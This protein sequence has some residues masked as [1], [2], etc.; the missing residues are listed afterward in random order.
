MNHS[1]KRIVGFALI[2]ALAI[3]V[4]AY[5]VHHWDLMEPAE[6]SQKLQGFGAWGPV[7]IIVMMV[8]HSFVPIP[9]EVLALTAGAVFGTLMGAVLIWIGAMLGA[10]LSYWIAYK[11]GAAGLR[12]WAPAKHVKT[13]DKWTEAPSPFALL[14]ARFMPI[15]AF[16]LINYAAGLARI[17]FGMFAWTTGVGIIPLVLL[18]PYLGSEMRD[19]TWASLLSLSAA[20]IVI[21]LAVWIVAKKLPTK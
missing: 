9:A 17:P 8:L 13:L 21:T 7:L 3:G 10:A 12:K 20:L 4:L 2:G 16:N 11:L 19:M 14:I 18:S 6:L 5:A 15:I 1:I